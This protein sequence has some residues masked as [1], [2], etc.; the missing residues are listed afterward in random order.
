MSAICKIKVESFP[1]L[2]YTN[3]IP[4]CIHYLFNLEKDLHHIDNGILE[5]DKIYLTC[6]IKEARERF[7]IK[8]CVTFD[9]A[10]QS[11]EYLKY[12]TFDYKRYLKQYIDEDRNFNHTNRHI[13]FEKWLSAFYKVLVAANNLFG[14]KEFEGD[15][16]V[17]FYKTTHKNLSKIEKVILDSFVFNKCFD[18]FLGL[19]SGYNEYYFIK[20]FLEISEDDWVIE[21]DLSDVIASGYGN[22][23][24]VTIDKSQ[25]AIVLCEG[26][27]DVFF[28][29]DIFDLI[30]P[31]YKNCFY[32][33]EEQEFLSGCSNLCQY[34]V[35][36]NEIHI[37]E[38]VIGIFDNDTE[39]N[40]QYNLA[41]QKVNAPNI[42]IMKLPFLKDF[43]RYPYVTVDNRISF[44]NINSKAISIELFYPD[45]VLKY[46][47]TFCPIMWSNYDKNEKSYQGKVLKKEELHERWKKELKSIKKDISLYDAYNYRRANS[48][49]EFIIN[50][51]TNDEHKKWRKALHGHNKKDVYIEEK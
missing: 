3:H 21:C 12:D 46:G 41:I 25:K 43:I 35:V 45:S 47:A 17:D 28:I 20:A 13:T 6:T 30:K 37:K 50:L 49:I 15:K 18:S 31:E 32:F 34:L 9:E 26:T 29:K 42:K 19:P 36:F 48:L 40:K 23:E 5:D 16:F 27:S 1:V 22:Y 51:F 14:N 39:G 4:E 11:F 38:N 33:T 10:R 24:D 7:S 2:E 44:C 8:R